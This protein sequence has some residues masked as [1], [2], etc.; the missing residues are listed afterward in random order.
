M[1]KT[2]NRIDSLVLLKGVH[3]SYRII[4][5]KIIEVDVTLRQINVDPLCIQKIKSIQKIFFIDP[6]AII[7]TSKNKIISLA[8]LKSGHRVII[9]FVKLDGGQQLAKGITV[10]K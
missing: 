9:D 8:G 5:V 6:Q 1:E 3:H 10:L 7:A 4:N 2:R